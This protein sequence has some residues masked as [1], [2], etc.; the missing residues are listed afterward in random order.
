MKV[1]FKNLEFVKKEIERLIKKVKFDNEV[2]AVILFGSSVRK[3]KYKNSDVD[4]CI[5]LRPNKYNSLRLSYKKL[6]YLKEFDFDIQIFQ[7]LPLYIRKRVIK[8][9]K[10]LF[11]RNED[12]LYQV[13]FKM[14]EEFADFEHIYREY[15]EEVSNVR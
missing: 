8:E 11:C 7:Q 1:N 10:V 9:G 15:L 12:E 4:I 13:V 6:K 2:L 14:I 5:V 3:Q